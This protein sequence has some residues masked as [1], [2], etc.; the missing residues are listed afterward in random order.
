MCGFHYDPDSLKVY[1]DEV[2]KVSRGALEILLV[3]KPDGTPVAY[4]N[5]VSLSPDY[6]AAA[7]SAVSGVIRSVLE[8][9]ELGDY[10]RIYVEL[11][12]KRYVF[13]MPF[14]GDVVVAVTKSNPN[15]GF[16]NMLLSVYFK[17]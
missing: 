4:A 13:A 15:L 10:K 8:M 6:L 7:I 16:I 2:L 17:D 3:S 11:T 5:S 1:L 12:D 14:R 9:L